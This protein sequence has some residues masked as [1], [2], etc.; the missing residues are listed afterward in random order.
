MIAPRSAGK[1][2]ARDVSPGGSRLFI[3][4]PR[5]AARKRDRYLGDHIDLMGQV[6]EFVAFNLPVAE[7]QPI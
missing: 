2:G 7:F 4:S 6:N 1:R 5:P 3:L